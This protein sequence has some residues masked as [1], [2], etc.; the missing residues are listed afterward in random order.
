MADNLFSGLDKIGLG[1]LNGMEL[2]DKEEPQAKKSVAASNEPQEEKVISEEEYTFDKKYKCP[3]CDSDFKVK[4]IKTGKAKLLGVDK[5]L[6]PKYQGVDSLKYDSVVCTKCG[7]AAL[8]RYFNFVSSAQIKLI[9][10]KITPYFKGVDEEC[11]F[12][13]YDEAIMRHQLALA[14]AVIKKGKVSERAYI[15]LKLAWLYRGKKENLPEDEKDRDK[16]IKELEETE[17]QFIL[18]SYE[19]FGTAMYKEPYPLAGMDEWT[20]AYLVANLAIIAEE[21]TKA[22]KLL[23]DII[24]SKVATSKLKDKARD[25]R[26]EIQ[27]KV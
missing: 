19:G 1:M 23:S 21:Y 6:R 16:V 2:Y 10:E 13:S 20:C 7:Y 25:L 3:V 12:Y 17:K 14:N 22:L 5:D 18:K 4:A 26:K 15:C 24:V 9:R 11:T 27:D 8:G